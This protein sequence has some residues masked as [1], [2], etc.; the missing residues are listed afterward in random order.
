[1][2]EFPPKWSNRKALR[3]GYLL[4]KG[5]QATDIASLLG[6][7]TTGGTVRQMRRY[8]KLKDFDKSR[9]A[10]HVAVRLSSY[11]LREI[12][13]AALKR[14]LSVEEWIRQVAVSAA[15]PED[16]FHAIVP[17]GDV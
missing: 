14:G 3:V 8:A 11:Q 7:G 17:E 2:P 5:R 9:G 1:M 15:I 10:I 16:I 12:S 13:R 4:G 6:D